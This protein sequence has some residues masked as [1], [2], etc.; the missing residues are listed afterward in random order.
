M[1]SDRSRARFARTPTIACVGWQRLAAMACC[2]IS[3][4]VS[5]SGCGGDDPTA[6]GP[7][8]V[9]GSSLPFTPAGLDQAV[10]DW[11]DLVVDDDLDGSYEIFTDECRET[12]TRDRWATFFSENRDPFEDELTASG[13]RLADLPLVV[14]V[15]WKEEGPTDRHRA[16]HIGLAF[17]DGEILEST[18]G[19]EYLQLFGGDQVLWV[20][21]DG[22][23]RFDDACDLGAPAPEGEAPIEA[24]A[25]ALIDRFL[26][27][28]TDA[29]VGWVEVSPLHLD[30]LKSG[31]PDAA[32]TEFV[33][34]AVVGIGPSPSPPPAVYALAWV[35][36][37]RH[38]AYDL[39]EAL[40]VDKAA[41]CLANALAEHAND[42]PAEVGPLDTFSGRPRLLAIPLAAGRVVQFPI[43][44]EQA[45]SQR[46]ELT[47]GHDG[48]IV[49]V[50]AIIESTDSPLADDDVTAISESLN[51]RIMGPGP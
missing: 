35:V 48:P 11:W 20:H 12:L 3:L 9:P 19:E 23:W 17:D 34:A 22:A 21:S 39:S 49:L 31:C 28:A 47:I 44:V 46:V 33:T 5:S 18:E 4:A 32:P 42:K 27:R 30:V 37:D 6:N 2:I 15:D 24:D 7:A 40:G 26:F 29:P 1:A 43:E 45:G 50:A 10:R 51:A 14:D 16:V 36:Q 38:V 8:G 25:Q 41:R 13:L